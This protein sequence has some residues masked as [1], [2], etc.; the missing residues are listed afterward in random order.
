MSDPAGADPPSPRVHEP[1]STLA[2]AQLIGACIVSVIVAAAFATVCILL[3]FHEFPGSSKDIA[4]LVV[5]GLLT[6]FGNVVSYWT[7]SSASSTQKSATITQFAN[8]TP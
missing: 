8:K 1:L 7:G 2:R 6:Q 4:M 3:F 5:G